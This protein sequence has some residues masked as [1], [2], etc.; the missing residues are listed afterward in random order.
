LNQDEIPEFWKANF[1]AGAQAKPKASIKDIM[2]KVIKV[3][4]R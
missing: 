3:I 1:E 4:D 2:K